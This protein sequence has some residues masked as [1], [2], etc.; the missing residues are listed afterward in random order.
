MGRPE[1]LYDEWR[2]GDEVADAGDEGRKIAGRGEFPGGLLAIMGVEEG[3]GQSMKVKLPLKVS[4]KNVYTMTARS[5]SLS[6]VYIY[7]HL[8]KP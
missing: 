3:F 2:D 7:L 4:F 6:N 5:L 8:L 1:L